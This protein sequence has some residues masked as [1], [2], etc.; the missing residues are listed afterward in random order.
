MD[1]RTRQAVDKMKI[2]LQCEHFLKSTRQCKK[3][4]CFMP[5]KVRIPRQKCPIQ[6]W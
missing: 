1:D 6:K 5:L 2:C 3:C 4:G